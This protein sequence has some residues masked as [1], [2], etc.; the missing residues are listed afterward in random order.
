MS[1][2][3]KDLIDKI[4]LIKADSEFIEVPESVSF[5]NM[6]KRLES[7]ENMEKVCDFEESKNNKGIK[8]KRKNWIAVCTGVA[9][10]VVAAILMITL[11]TG[12]IG[13]VSHINNGN[14]TGQNHNHEVNKNQ[15]LDE[16]EEQMKV[17]ADNGLYVLSGYK[18]LSDY[19]AASRVMYKDNFYDSEYFG[20]K[21]G[22]DLTEQPTLMPEDDLAQNS[23]STSVPEGVVDENIGD[24]DYS[25]TN[26]RTEGVGEA[27]IV[28]TDGDYIYYVTCAYQNSINVSIAITKAEGAK[29]NKMSEVHISGDIIKAAFAGEMKETTDIDKVSM[30]NIDMLVCGDKLMVVA[31][32]DLYVSNVSTVIL[33]FDISDRCNPKLYS[34]LSLEG[35]YDSCKLVDGYIYIFAELTKYVKVENIVETE[36]MA[37]NIYAPK[38]CDRL[39]P[40]EDVYVAP[41]TSYNT[42]N[43]VA[44]LDTGDM[45]QFFDVKA[46]LSA[47]NSIKRYVSGSNIYFIADIG[48]D[49]RNVEKYGEKNT[50]IEMAYQSQIMRFSYEKGVITPTG[51]VNV[52]GNIGDEFDIDEYNGYLRLAVSSE[53]REVTYA[54]EKVYDTPKWA[55][56]NDK[57]YSITFGARNRKSALYIYDSNLQLVGS[58]PELQEEE[59]VY[60][61]RFDGD[62]AYIVTYRQTD[63]L[64]T[65]DLSDPA[66]PKVMG[67]LKIP[68]FSTYLHKWDDNKLL[69]IGYDEWR[70]IK[71]STYDIADK[72]DVKEMDI[73]ILQSQYYSEALYDH[74][75]LFISPEKN[76]IGFA[77]EG[78]VVDSA[79]GHGELRMLYKIFSYVDGKLT[80]VINS[81]FDHTYLA[82]RG[83]YIGEY[84][85]IVNPGQGI[86]VY[87][88]NDYSKVA[89]AY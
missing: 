77:T 38:V 47:S 82:M 23:P 1:K 45:S 36:D 69:G 84:I 5:D 30:S 7:T 6:L 19:I 61:V 76:L 29:T 10:T 58:I 26:V 56:S 81:E 25:D 73:C 51:C 78:Y 65:V 42:Y 59:E 46:V 66:N 48:Y 41:S 34:S 17:M 63:P 40:A 43:I 44:V 18:E 70:Q 9:G 33:T 39:L 2:L 87:S 64:F 21:F 55:I 27:D 67:A 37:A 85:Y 68:G 20:G 74:K 83:L 28:K 12:D 88:I 62:I 11:L 79:T 3:N 60:G 53:T 49:Y 35:A 14:N 57:Q 86:M 24:K 13:K 75:A 52:N 50:L 80:E 15:T 72:Y 54:E 4:N 89:E 32:L 31:S 22:N 16:Y 8:H 71:I